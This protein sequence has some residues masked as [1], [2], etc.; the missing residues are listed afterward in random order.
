MLNFNESVDWVVCQDSLKDIL[1][2]IDSDY[3][4]PE[5]AEELNHGMLVLTLFYSW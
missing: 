4:S 2:L 5:C 1:N 3:M